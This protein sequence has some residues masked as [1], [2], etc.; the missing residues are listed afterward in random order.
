M[1]LS[2]EM[3]GKPRTFH[4]GNG[5]IG[6]SLE[7]LGVSVTELFETMGANPYKIVP[8]LMHESYKFNL[9]MEGKPEDDVTVDDFVRWTSQVPDIED[10]PMN[11]W[12]IAFTESRTK[13]LPKEDPKSSNS[14]GKKRPVKK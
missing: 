2:I 8:I 1:Q 9:W 13:H 7:R 4:F 12:I 3:G 14:K 11:K 5:F 10:G 6:N